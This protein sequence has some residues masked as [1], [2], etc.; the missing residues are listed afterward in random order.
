V[1]PPQETVDKDT[2]R[3]RRLTHRTIQR[4]TDLE[5]QFN[6]IIAALMEMTN[7]LYRLREKAEGTVEW[8]L[9]LRNMMLLMAPVTPHIAEELWLLRSGEGSVHTQEWPVF[10]PSKLVEDTVEVVV[11]VNGKLRDRLNLAPDA[12]EEQALAAAQAS[13]KVTGD[14]RKGVPEGYLCPGPSPEPRCVNVLQTRGEMRG[15]I[16]VALT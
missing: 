4:V 9:A 7:A 5:N 2:A 8:D 14:R 3:T 10:D 16:R 11:Q 12:T 6:T 1:A 13:P 15:D